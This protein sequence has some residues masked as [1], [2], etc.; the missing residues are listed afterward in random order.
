MIKLCFRA[1]AHHRKIRAALLT[2]F[3]LVSVLSVAHAV[4]PPPRPP[5]PAA[6]K[7]N[8][9]DPARIHADQF[10]FD[11]RNNH[12]SL[13]GDVKIIWRGWTV[14][15]DRITYVPG[16]GLTAQGDVRARSPDNITF[17]ADDL[18]FD[19]ELS[20][21]VV[22]AAEALLASTTQPDPQAPVRFIAATIRRDD[23]GFIRFTDARYTACAPCEDDPDK[24]PQWQLRAGKVTY[25]RARHQITLR[26]ISLEIKGVP[27]AWLP[28]LRLPDPTVAKA[29]GFLSPEFDSRR[30]TGETIAIP[31]FWNLDPSYDLLLTPE[32][33]RKQGLIPHVEWRQRTPSGRYKLSGSFNIPLSQTQGLP[34]RDWRGH[35]FGDGNFK[36]GQRW[37]TGFNAQLASDPA[38]LRDYGIDKSEQLTNHAY[39]RGQSARGSLNVDAYSFQE[40]T[41]G[42]DSDLDDLIIVAPEIRYTHQLSTPIFGGTTVLDAQ[43]LNLLHPGKQETQRLSVGLEWD[44]P[45]LTPPGLVLKPYILARGSFY[46]FDAKDSQSRLDDTQPA[47]LFAATGLEINWPWLHYTSSLT[48]TLNPFMALRFGVVSGDQAGVPNEDSRGV[49]LDESLLFSRT[50]FPGID[51]YDIGGRLDAGIQ[52]RLH[53]ESGFTGQVTIGESFHIGAKP[54]FNPRSGFNENVRSDIVTAVDIAYQNDWRLASRLRFDSETFDVERVEIEAH[55]RWRQWD[56][57]LAYTAIEDTGQSDITALY[58]EQIMSSVAWNVTPFWQIGGFLRYDLDNH[59]QLANGV[60]ISYSDE[61]L[62]VQL[63]YEED[64]IDEGNFRAGRS[65][66]LRLNLR[67]LGGF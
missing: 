17:T 36:L 46:N 30:V 14:R 2:L 43:M 22:S 1:S 29:S 50:K 35:L 59:R 39:L 48:Q 8:H 41:E 21:F 47:R 27:I 19:P 65:L 18:T 25:D 67:T 12:I 26:Q 58:Q 11:Q 16:E 13:H 61:C 55:G 24:S 53:H 51:R 6:A 52:Y 45:L 7:T 20:Q 66:F 34:R 28:W 60:K 56:A 32:I 57:T 44:R 63:A 10:I 54:L 31:Y 62:D 37:Q 49:E 42:L 4:E 38:Y 64:F 9:P 3:L 23:D 33:S 15:A 40:L 5:T